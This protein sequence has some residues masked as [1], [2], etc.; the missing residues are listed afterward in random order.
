[1]LEPHR[2]S[3]LVNLTEPSSLWAFSAPIKRLGGEDGQLLLQ[4]R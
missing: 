1:M 2:Q 3:R 4:N